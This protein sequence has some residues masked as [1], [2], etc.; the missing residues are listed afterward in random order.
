M[1]TSVCN[2]SPFLRSDAQGLLRAKH[3][4]WTVEP[5][6]DLFSVAEVEVQVDAQI[7]ISASTN[8]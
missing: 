2:L 8:L 1:A 6:Q 7:E 3:M 4:P 5:V